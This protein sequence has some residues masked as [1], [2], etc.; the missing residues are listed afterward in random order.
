MIKKYILEGV[1]C[2]GCSSIDTSQYKQGFGQE[3][4]GR[5]EEFV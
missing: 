2:G 5:R 4:I 1:W 3:G